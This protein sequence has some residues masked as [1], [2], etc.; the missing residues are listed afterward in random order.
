MQLEQLWS[1]YR[2]ALNAF[3]LSKV[4]NPQDAEDL[5]QD[6][7]I[8]THKNLDKLREARSIKAWLFQI[9]NNTIIDFYR[10]RARSHEVQQQLDEES[11][12]YSQS[13]QSIKAELSHCIE[14]F[15]QCLSEANAELLTAIDLNGESQKVYAEQL[16]ISYSTLKSRVQKAR[17]ELRG[18]FDRC[19][20]MQLDA[21]GNL[22]DYERKDSC[23]GC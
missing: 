5:L 15:I 18:L 23:N 7:L 17:T 4:S 19:C 10:T 2:S 3:L 14:P 11:L 20:H 12:W 1:E 9:A 13:E 22:M 8:K 21:Q 6:I 16:G